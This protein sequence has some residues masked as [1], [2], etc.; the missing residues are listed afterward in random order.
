MLIRY[1]RTVSVSSII[2]NN[3]NKFPPISR[4]VSSSSYA[5]KLGFIPFPDWS[6]HPY[7]IPHPVE[8]FD[9]LSSG[10]SCFNIMLSQG[11]A[12]IS[13]YNFIF[14][15]LAKIGSYNTVL[16]LFKKLDES[17]Q[18]SR[19]HL[20]SVSPDIHTWAILISCHSTIGNMSSAIS[21]FH[22][23]IDTGHHP[24]PDTLYNLLEGFC[25]KHEIHK[26]MHFYNDII[27][28]KGFQFDDN[29]YLILI[30]ELC[31]IGET[32]VAIQL[33]RHALQIDKKPA[34]G[35]FTLTCL[36]NIIIFRLCKDRLVKPNFSLLLK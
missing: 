6:D 3:N 17:T 29:C 34:D 22:K 24:T 2:P 16:S 15:N 30:K 26:A 25:R 18:F 10:V 20:R 35:G 28:K 1:G 5:S 7:N 8:T 31:E 27:L 12:S 13:D 9:T 36:Y 21:L 4:F 33:L 14:E 23:I 32:H 11:V 19:H